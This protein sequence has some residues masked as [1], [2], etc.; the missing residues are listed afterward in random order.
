M[1]K[2]LEPLQ[3][4]LDTR[5][6]R[7]TRRNHGLEHATIHVLSAKMKNLSVVG[8]SDARGF[9]LYGNIPTDAIEEAVNT[10]RDRMLKGE[11]SLAIHPNCGTNLVTAASLSAVAVFTT[12]IGSEH[13]RGGKLARLPLVILGIMMALIFA[14][15]LGMRI[16]QNIT[17]L[18]DL[19]D[20]QILNIRA[21]RRR[22]MTIHRV[23]TTST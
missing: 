22:N 9:Y 11:H 23:V 12:L 19:G 5:F 21:H 20:L 18:G 14:Q 3:V 6:V 13:E 10:A 7:R 8:R 2:L 1:E 16:Q 15:P 17:T 4:V